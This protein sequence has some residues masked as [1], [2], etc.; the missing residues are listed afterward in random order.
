[1]F[2]QKHSILLARV[3]VQP[4]SG[5]L[6]TVRVVNPSPTPVTLYRHT[7]L[8]TFTEVD[9][10]PVWSPDESM[11]VLN[12]GEAPWRPGTTS[13]LFDLETGEL[14]QLEKGKVRKLLEEFQNIF[15]KEPN[16]H[17]RT[18]KV[19]HR[20]KTG[21]AVPIKQAPRRV[22]AHQ[23]EEVHQHLSKMAQHQVIQPPNSPWA[24]PIVLVKDGITRFCVDYCKLNNETLKDTYPLPRIADI[25]D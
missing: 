1:M 21:D 4:G 23:K 10:N 14:T 9:K 3:L 15:S 16:D 17:G 22:H 2:T 24:S 18:S 13:E 11:H 8:G 19:Q 7:H 5:N 6:V 12:V 20:I 25:L